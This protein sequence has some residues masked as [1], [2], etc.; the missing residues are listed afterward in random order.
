MLAMKVFLQRVSS[1][2]VDVSGSSCAELSSS[3][4]LLLLVGIAAKDTDQ[5]MELMAKKIANLRVFSDEAGKFQYSVLDIKGGIICVPQFTLFADTTRGRRP[6]FFSAM[7][8]PQAKTLFD[9]F[10]DHLSQ[11]GVIEV[12]RGVFGSHME[13]KIVNDGPVSMML[14]N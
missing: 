12:E 1:A 10:C 13:V 11:E 6:D 8:P 9:T 7:R 2:A 3:Q 5:N 4:G 14:E